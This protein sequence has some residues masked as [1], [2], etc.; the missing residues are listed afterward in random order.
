MTRTASKPAASDAV[1]GAE[2]AHFAADLGRLWPDGG[3][4]G[5]AVSGGSDSLALLLL[6]HAAMPGELAVATVDHGLRPEARDECAMVARVCDTLGVTYA[7]LTIAVPP[8]S[9]PRKISPLASA[10]ASSPEK[11]AE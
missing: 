3:R 10:I 1:S 7:V 4:L 2:R 11:K 5:L 9:R 8:G 6:A